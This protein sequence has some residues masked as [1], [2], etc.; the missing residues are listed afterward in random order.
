MLDVET[1]RLQLDSL[2]TEK[3]KLLTPEIV[4]RVSQAALCSRVRIMAAH[5][6]VLPRS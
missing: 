6:L 5:R 3:L 4:K 1:V 2:M